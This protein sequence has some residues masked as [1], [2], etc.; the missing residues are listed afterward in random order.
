MSSAIE[1][2]DDSTLASKVTSIGNTIASIGTQLAS[3]NWIGAAMSAIGAGIGYLIGKIE[4][5]KKRLEKILE[6]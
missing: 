3:G 5:E 2:W 6:F 1:N 4:A